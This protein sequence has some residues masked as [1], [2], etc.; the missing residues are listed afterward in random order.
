MEFCT[1]VLNAFGPKESCK[2]FLMYAGNLPASWANMTQLTDL[3]IV[4]GPLIT[5]PFPTEWAAGSLKLQRLEL[6]GL[7]IS[8]PLNAI[9][10]ISSITSLTLR[11][12]AAVTLPA[13]LTALV[14]NTSATLIN[15]K[16]IAGWAGQPLN[17]DIPLT[18]PNIST[19]ALSQLGLVGSIPAS[20]ESFKA[21]QLKDLYLSQN[22]LTGMLP[23]WLGLRIARG[24]ALDVGSNNFT[25]RH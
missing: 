7:G 8:G 11:S 19:L 3:R 6:N 16:G 25:G 12:M 24:F 21:Q 13:T 22:M 20:W 2:S 23:S 10:N 4:S 15:L 17:A 14:P 9:G 18:Y 5:G 1:G